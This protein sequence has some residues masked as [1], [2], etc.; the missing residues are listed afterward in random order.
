MTTVKQILADCNSGHVAQHVR[1]AALLS[2]HLVPEA[3]HETKR[4]P[5][6]KLRI[7]KCANQP[8]RPHDEEAGLHVS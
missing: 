6:L 7:T 4:M 1:L 3:A 8:P 5:R 2:V